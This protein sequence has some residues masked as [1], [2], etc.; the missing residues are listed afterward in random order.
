MC[1]PDCH[2]RYFSVW[3]LHALPVSVLVLLASS[4]FY[5][6]PKT[7]I[8]GGG[9]LAL[10]F[11]S[12]IRRMVLSSPCFRFKLCPD[13]LTSACPTWAS[14]PDWRIKMQ[15]K[16][17][18]AVVEVRCVSCNNTASALSYIIGG[19]QMHCCISTNQQERR[20]AWL[21]LPAAR[22]FHG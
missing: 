10:T 9:K 14:H 5:H 6:S 13:L 8:W 15:R 7:C 11:S 2:H 3:S 19:R 18:S 4:G 20:E 1:P 21:S 16:C 12:S 17:A 22:K